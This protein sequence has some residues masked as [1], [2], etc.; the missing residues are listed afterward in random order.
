[1]LLAE[2]HGYIAVILTKYETAALLDTLKE[3][4]TE[5]NA[6]GDLNDL[7][8]CILQITSDRILPMPTFIPR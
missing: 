3:I 7:S 2:L 6:I 5:P 4:C 8:C 1:M